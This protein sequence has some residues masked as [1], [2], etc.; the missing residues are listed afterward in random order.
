VSGARVLHHVGAADDGSAEA[1]VIETE[2]LILRPP[3]TADRAALH[4]IWSDPLVM[5]DLGPVKSAADSAATLTRHAGYGDG[6]GFH[7]VV[8]RSDAA[9]I[10]FCGLKPGAPATPRRGRTRRAAP[11]PG[12]RP[13]GS[14]QRSPRTGFPVPGPAV[15]GGPSP[16]PRKTMSRCPNAPAVV[17][18]H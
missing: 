8:R 5:A 11:F 16:T 12:T 14:G 1:L 4:A 3:T 7:A 10:G 17:D 18:I 2:R 15:R 6:L 9:V 13:R